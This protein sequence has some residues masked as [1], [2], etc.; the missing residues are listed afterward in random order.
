MSENFDA[1]PKGYI[2]C[3]W[4]KHGVR[5]SSR[6]SHCRLSLEAPATSA[7]DVVVT[8]AKKPKK[9]KQEREA[10]KTFS[11]A[12]GVATVLGID[13]GARYTGIIVRD[14][15]EPIYSAIFVRPVD[16]GST[17]WAL[18]SVRLSLEVYET[19]QPTHVALEGISDPKGFYKGQQAAINPKDIIR[20]GVVLGALVATWP[21]AIIV[22]PGG[23]GDRHESFYPDAL[24]GRRPKTLAG[25]N[26]GA[27][28]RK[29]EKSAYDVAGKAMRQL[30][31]I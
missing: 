5:Q 27:N 3:P 6:C 25:S 16:M 23:N 7:V 29:H 18:E 30:G 31:L 20:T 14:N 4:C 15:D 17:D 1:L 9:P 21:E 10:G 26:K 28:T 12:S 13:P 24:N 11:I 22:D 8:T 19:Y 2:I